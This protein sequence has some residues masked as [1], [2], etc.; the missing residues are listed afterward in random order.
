MAEVRR[1][2]VPVHR[3]T[4]RHTIAT[5]GFC[6]LPRPTTASLIVNVVHDPQVPEPDDRA[7]DA[8]RRAPRSACG[9]RSRAGPSARRSRPRSS[10]RRRG[11]GIRPR[12]S[13]SAATIATRRSV[14]MPIVRP[15]TGRSSRNDGAR[16]SPAGLAVGL[17]TQTVSAPAL[18][19]AAPICAPV[20]KPYRYMRTHAIFTVACTGI[21]PRGGRKVPGQT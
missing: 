7:V 16:T 15:A 13:R 11:A 18:L 2:V 9:R 20:G 4:P 5:T 17:R 14:R 8:V 21:V 19:I 12:R 3:R 1:D 10:R 6:V